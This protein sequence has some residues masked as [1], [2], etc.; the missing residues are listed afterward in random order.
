MC[1]GMVR[2]PGV[3]RGAWGWQGDERL[4]DAVCSAG[5]VRLRQGFGVTA[6]VFSPKKRRLVHRE[7]EPPSLPRSVYENSGAFVD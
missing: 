2:V 3:W 7:F 4:P 5:V 6:S 1:L